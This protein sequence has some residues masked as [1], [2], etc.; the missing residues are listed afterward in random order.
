LLYCEPSITLTEES[1]V[2]VKCIYECEKL[3]GKYEENFE[4]KDGKIIKTSG[5]LTNKGNKVKVKRG[6]GKGELKAILPLGMHKIGSTNVIVVK[7]KK[8]NIKFLNKPFLGIPTK[9]KVDIELEPRYNFLVKVYGATITSNGEHEIIPVENDN[10][11]CIDAPQAEKPC[12]ELGLPPPKRL[13]GDEALV[14]IIDVDND[15]LVLY[16]RKETT[17]RELKIVNELQARLL[18]TVRLKKL[19]ELKTEGAV[20]SLAFDEEGALGTASSEYIYLLDKDYTNKGSLYREY[21]GSWT[22]HVSYLPREGAFGFT[23]DDGCIYIVKKFG[24]S[25]NIT[26]L[27]VER[28]FN[29]SI[30]PLSKGFIICGRECGYFDSEGIERWSFRVGLVRAPSLQ[31]GLLLTYQLL[32]A[33]Y[34]K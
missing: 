13:S 8:K 33:P 6:R 25:K 34:T 27:C 31:A 14:M 5:K 21:V 23:T 2:E 15:Q 17:F 22:N 32:R 26:K 9:V 1:E 24:R 3:L 7:V 19:K 28:E 11:L 4:L 16:D 20:R 10:K 18:P 29:T 12:I 30:S